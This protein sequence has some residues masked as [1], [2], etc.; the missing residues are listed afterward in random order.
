[1]VI[2]PR[3]S[4]LVLGRGWIK[5]SFTVDE[6]YNPITW[7]IKELAKSKWETKMWEGECGTS[8]YREMA[9]AET[10]RQ[11][12]IRHIWGLVRRLD[13]SWQGI[14]TLVDWRPYLKPYILF[15]SFLG[16]SVGLLVAS[17][18]FLGRA[19]RAGSSL[20]LVIML[21][22]TSDLWL[23]LPSRNTHLFFAETYWFFFLK[24]KKLMKIHFTHFL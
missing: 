20:G 21:V 19:S 22:D 2:V 3:A 1:M 18:E 24:R 23:F 12:E 10:Q 8:W 7:Q 6:K 9:S 13:Y 16:K 15:I 14:F 4:D 5:E 11:E 17:K